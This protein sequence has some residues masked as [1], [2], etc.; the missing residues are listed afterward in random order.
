MPQNGNVTPYEKKNV[1]DYSQNP[2]LWP[3]FPFFLLPCKTISVCVTRT[4]PDGIKDFPSPTFLS[5]AFHIIWINLK[6]NF[7]ECVKEG[8]SLYWDFTIKW[9]S[10]KYCLWLISWIITRWIKLECTEGESCWIMRKRF[11]LIKTD[12]QV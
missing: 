1:W 11:K 9:A 2:F 3:F 12:G 4:S 7:W 8:R 5:K 10:I 6:G